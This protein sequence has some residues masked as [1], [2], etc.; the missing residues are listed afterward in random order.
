MALCPSHLFSQSIEETKGVFTLTPRFVSAHTFRGTYLGD[1]SFQP[2]LEYSKG[3]L[4][5]ELFANFTLTNKIPAPDP[6]EHEIDLTASYQWDII[7]E[8]LAIESTVALYT[9]PR[10]INRDEFYKYTVEPNLSFIYSIGRVLFLLTYYYDIV[11]KGATYEAGIDFSFPIKD[12]RFEIEGEACTGKYDWSDTVPNA[13]LKVRSNGSYFNS[14]IS[15][16]YGF[17]E[18]IKLSVGWC[19]EKGTKNYV[20]IGHVKEPDSSATSCGYYSVALA[21]SF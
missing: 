8:V 13:P 19:Y 16:L 14:G 18:N 10:L 20:Q 15:V 17:T 9:F 7:P 4:T 1:P 11:I 12:T 6:V 21:Y 5:L 3:S 2:L